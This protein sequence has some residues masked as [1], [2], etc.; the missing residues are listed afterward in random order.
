M[1]QTIVDVE[2]SIEGVARQLLRTK[3]DLAPDEAGLCQAISIAWT[4]QARQGYL[5]LDSWYPQ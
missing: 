5:Y 3:A 1:I 2:D 4:F